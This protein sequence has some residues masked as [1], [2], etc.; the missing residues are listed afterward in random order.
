MA[1]QYER[2]H[3][4]C[5]VIRENENKICIFSIV[6]FKI[7]AKNCLLRPRIRID[8]PFNKRCIAA[9]SPIMHIIYSFNEYFERPVHPPPSKRIITVKKKKKNVSP[10]LRYMLL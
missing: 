9:D 2:W 4:L 10:R 3:V 1:K 5:Y 8:N 6:L 7:A